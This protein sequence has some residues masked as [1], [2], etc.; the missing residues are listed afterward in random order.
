MENRG[1]KYK[2]IRYSGLVILLIGLVIVLFIFQYPPMSS[3][4]YWTFGIGSIIFLIGDLMV[5][6]YEIF[7]P[8][9]WKGEWSIGPDHRYPPEKPKNK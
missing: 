4:L 5:I 8:E 6:G 7:V 3:G 1:K 9:Y 2:L